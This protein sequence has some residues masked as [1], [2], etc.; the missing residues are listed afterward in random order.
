MEK[1]LNEIFIKLLNGEVDDPNQLSK[2]VIQLSAHLFNLDKNRI[3]SEQN[4]SK[5]WE[6]KRSDF[7]SDKQC[8]MSLRSSPEW[9]DFEKSKTNY[10]MCLEIIR[11][12]KKRL[13][14]LSDM[15]QNSY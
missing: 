14:V 7:K 15:A 3:Q 6:L 8:E 10:R 5:L 1:E 4:W 2:W 9:L 11:A 12:S 13:T